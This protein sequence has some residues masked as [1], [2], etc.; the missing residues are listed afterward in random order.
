MKIKFQCTNGFCCENSNK[1]HLFVLPAEM[2]MDEKNIAVIFCPK[3]KR[4]LK[5]IE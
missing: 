3:C 2:V 5:R 1:E 4:E